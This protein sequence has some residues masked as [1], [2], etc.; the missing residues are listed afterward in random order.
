MEK[1]EPKNKNLGDNLKKISE[2]SDWFDGREAVDL[3]QGLEKI[4]EAAGLIKTSRGR[5]KEIENEFEEIK[6]EIEAE[7]EVEGSDQEETESPIKDDAN[8]EDMPF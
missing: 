2:I 5:L 7:D 4:K 1:N 6:K 3:E 8:I